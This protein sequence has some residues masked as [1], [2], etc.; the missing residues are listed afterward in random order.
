[1]AARSMSSNIQTHTQSRIP[2]PRC[3]VAGVL[4]E[5]E[6]RIRGGGTSGRREPGGAQPKGSGNSAPVVQGR[7]GEAEEAGEAKG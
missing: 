5:P 6:A 2:K 7:L 1:M 4:G 3:R